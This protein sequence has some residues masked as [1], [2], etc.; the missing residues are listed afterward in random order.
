MVGLMILKVFSNQNDSI[1]LYTEQ[2]Q[3]ADSVHHFIQQYVCFEESQQLF[4]KFSFRRHLF[5]L[6]QYY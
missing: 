4:L 2:H 6:L 3:Y 1:I 5:A